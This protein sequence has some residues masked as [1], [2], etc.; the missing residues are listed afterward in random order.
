M[1][2]DANERDNNTKE[3]RYDVFAAAFPNA[4]IDIL[5][6]TNSIIDD[7]HVVR[8]LLPKLV[9]DKSCVYA[10]D[11]LQNYSKARDEKR[12]IWKDHPEHD[13]FS[14]G[15]DTIRYYALGH[16]NEQDWI[17]TYEGGSSDSYS[18]ESFAEDE[19]EV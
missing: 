2:H 9:L 1:P 7:I 10:L 17:E 3:T 11:C 4:N 6:K 19:F 8:R 18:D 15:A 13:E 16:Q 12:N 14:H 5:K